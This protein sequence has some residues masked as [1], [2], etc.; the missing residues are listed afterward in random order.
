MEPVVVENVVVSM[1][2]VKEDV[3]PVVEEPETEAPVLEE[4]V[5]DAPLEEPAA[6]ETPEEE[7]ESIREAF[8]ESSEKEDAPEKVLTGKALVEQISE[9]EKQEKARNEEQTAPSVVVPHVVEDEPVVEVEPA[10]EETELVEEEVAVE[11]PVP[12]APVVVI[13][14]ESVGA[15]PAES[16]EEDGILDK[17]LDSEAI[18]IAVEVI[19]IMVIL[20]LSSVIRNRYSRPLPLGLSFLLAI[21]FTAIPMLIAF[22]LSGWS[23]LHLIYMVLIF[24]VFIFSSRRGH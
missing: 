20:A 15:A 24:T 14:E 7:P 17:A 4:P 2:E 6:V 22:I 9:D 18:S 10:V 21:L 16:R 3:P 19:S 23:N 11:S 8:I 12:S 5:V 13:Q 1:E